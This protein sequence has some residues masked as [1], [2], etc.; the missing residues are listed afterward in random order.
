[1]RQGY[2]YIEGVEVLLEDLKKN[3]FEMHAFTNYPVWYV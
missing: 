1:M 2:S 3:G